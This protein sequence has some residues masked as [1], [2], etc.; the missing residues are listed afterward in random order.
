M[1]T[2]D[3]Y[4]Q[5]LRAYENA[6]P[7]T[8][9]AYNSDPAAMVRGQA[10]STYDSPASGV[11]QQWLATLS[12]DQQAQYNALD[13]ARYGKAAQGHQI[14]FLAAVATM[15]IGGALAAAD[16]KSVV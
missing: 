6:N 4:T 9:P 3:Q 2:L 16:R 11:Y 10:D 13:S 5:M 14:G 7:Y 1:T 8:G 12:P 15:G